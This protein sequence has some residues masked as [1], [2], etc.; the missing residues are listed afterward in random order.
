MSTLRDKSA[1][2]PL[3]LAE[4]DAPA[5]TGALIISLS[6][7]LANTRLRLRLLREREDN[8]LQLLAEL[9]LGDD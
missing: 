4:R 1:A 2:L 8:L 6:R 3:T 5:R 7:E 9:E